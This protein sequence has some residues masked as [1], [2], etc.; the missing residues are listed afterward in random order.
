MPSSAE[1]WR[2]RELSRDNVVVHR[3]KRS[4]ISGHRIDSMVLRMLHQST[5]SRHKV[6]DLLQIVQNAIKL[7]VGAAI[8]QPVVAGAL[9]IGVSHHHVHAIVA[10]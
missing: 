6:H 2:I 1:S 5:V 10:T 9:G 3:V 8:A 7:V 4:I